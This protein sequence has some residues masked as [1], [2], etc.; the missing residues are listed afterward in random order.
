MELGYSTVHARH[1]F[2][3]QNPESFGS[4]ELAIDYVDGF[5]AF[6]N[7]I[8]IAP[9]N[10]GPDGTFPMNISPA[11]GEQ[12]AGTPELFAI[13]DADIILVSGANVLAV[14]GVNVALDSSDFSLR[15]ELRTGAFV[16]EACP[17]DLFVTGGQLTLSG[18]APVTET[19]FVRVN[20]VDAEY[21]RFT[22]DWFSTV[23]LGGASIAVTVEV[24]D[25]DL[26][27]LATENISASRVTTVG[28][29]VAVEIHRLASLGVPR[30]Q[31]GM[32]SQRRLQETLQEVA[33]VAASDSDESPRA[34]KLLI[35]TASR[36]ERH[37]AIESV[38]VLLK[39]EGAYGQ[40][41]LR[42]LLKSLGS[43]DV[44]VR[45]RTV[46]HLQLSGRDVSGVAP[47]LL[48]ALSRTGD[49]EVLSTLVS[50][51]GNLDTLES[52]RAILGVSPAPRSAVSG[53]VEERDGPGILGERVIEVLGMY[54]SQEVTDWL[55]GLAFE[56]AAMSP[57]H[58]TSN[59]EPCVASPGSASSRMR[60]A[61]SRNS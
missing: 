37:A 3:V 48:A 60:E 16:G 2:D 36:T 47:E 42:L 22:G 33:V 49:V 56:E 58:P 8:E 38:F 54:S 7:G 12:E 46:E 34:W 11:S 19:R 45:R 40:H 51:A 43:L 24:L 26:T 55:C 53:H 6:L 39:L 30:T 61:V 32:V 31:K 57:S 23:P 17:G 41:A 4:L 14:V 27:V 21:D 35:E 1:E 25:S 50:I 18:R 5:I 29:N 52:A 20:G 10:A 13:P 9:A 44:G 28:G 59:C 15:P